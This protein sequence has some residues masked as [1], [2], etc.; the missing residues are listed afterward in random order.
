[1]LLVSRTGPD[2]PGAADLAAELRAAGAGTTVAACD[3]TDRD[4]LARLLADV[5][6]DRPL[7]AV[8]HTAGVLA[9]ATVAA[10]TPERLAAA[11]RP[12]VD[13]AW[14]LH[15]LTEELPLDAFVL[16]SSAV[17][18]AGV[19]G[20][21][22]YAAGNT[23]LDALAAHRRALG[24][25]AVSLAWGLWEET[26]AMTGHLGAADRTRLARYGVGP[27]ATEAGLDALFAAERPHTIVSPLDEGL[28]RE[29]AAAG[30]L[31][32]VFGA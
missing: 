8:V 28:L 16:F 18:V 22:N 7:R 14:L 25:P 24:L 26:G 31:R 3:A 13:A 6:A 11:L 23:F 12:K 30:R 20:Q 4:A 9:D 27:V 1:L 19:P 29:E 21:A 5:P 2:A 10:L 17:A 15:E 32:P